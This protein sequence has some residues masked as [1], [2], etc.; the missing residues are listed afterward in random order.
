MRF[1][2]ELTWV[3]QIARSKFY[4]PSTTSDCGGLF[5][6][7]IRVWTFK[8]VSQPQLTKVFKSSKKNVLKKVQKLQ[9]QIGVW[10]FKRVSQ[11]Q[12]AKLFGTHKNIL[13]GGQGCENHRFHE[14]YV[15]FNSAD[16]MNGVSILRMR[17]L[18]RVLATLLHCYITTLQH[19]SATPP[20]V[21]WEF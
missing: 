14:I 2:V 10:T 11:P 1:L 6:G 12:L 4:H 9:G 5:Q 8:R 3:D 20:S 17:G 21:W 18:F 16:I 7:Q 13:S 15:V 19:C